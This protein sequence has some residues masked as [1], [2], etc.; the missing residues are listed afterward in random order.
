MT[1]GAIQATSNQYGQ[2]RGNHD[3]VSLNA[4]GI[5]QPE[6]YLRPVPDMGPSSEIREGSLGAQASDWV[7]DVD[8]VGDGLN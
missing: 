6:C 7:D 1:T 2:N 8:T 3:G 4:H 5:A